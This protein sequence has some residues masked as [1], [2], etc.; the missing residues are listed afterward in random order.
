MTKRTNNLISIAA[1]LMVSPAFATTFG[2]VENFD[3]VNDTGKV[4]HGFEIELEDM[5]ASEVISVFGKDRWLGMERY[6]VPT[7]TE[8]ANVQGVTGA[9]RTGGWNAVV[10]YRD[11]AKSTPSGT[12]PVNPADSCWPLGTP[13]YGP[14]YPCDHF[15]VASSVAAKNVNY[16]WLVEHTP[17][18]ANNL[19][20]VISGVPAPQWTV[21]PQPP[22]AVPNPIPNAPPI[23]QPQPP[24]VNVVIAV[25]PVPNGWEFGEAKWVKVTAT[26]LLQ[27]IDEG[28]LMAEGALMQNMQTQV[29]WQRLQTD[30]G[31]PLA[32][33]IDLTGVALDPGATGIAYRFEFYTYTGDY[34]P[35]THEAITAPD[36]SG[37]KTPPATVGKFIVAQM[38]GV[39]FDG[40]L[41]A[42]A[43]IPVAPTI[44]ASVVDA[45]LNGQYSATIN[46]TSGNVGDVLNYI[47]TGLPAGLTADP[48]TGVISGSV[49][50]AS[51][52]GKVF[53]LDIKVNDTTNGLS[54]GAQTTMTV[55]DGVINFAPVDQVGT[56]GSVFSYGLA[57]TGGTGIFT[58]SQAINVM[59]PNNVMSGGALPAGLLLDGTTGVIGGIPTLA[60]AYPTTFLATDSAGYTSSYMPIN[61]TINDP[62]IAPPAPTA[63]AGTNE[64][65]TGVN[66]QPN[67]VRD[68]WIETLG[69]AQNGGHSITIPR[70]GVNYT[71]APGMQFGVFQNHMVVTYKG[72]MDAAN[73]FCNATDVS[74]TPALTMIQPAPIAVNYNTAITPVVLQFAGGVAPYSV[75]VTN[76]PA[77]I[78]FD[79]MTNTISGAS[80]VVGPATIVASVTDF[81]GDMVYANISL[82]VNAPAAIVVG[83]STLP[84]GQATVKYPGGS[85]TATGGYGALS[86]TGTGLPPGLTISTAGVI[87]GT[88]T[89]AGTFNPTFTVVDGAGQSKQVAGSISIAPAPVVAT[90]SCTTPKGAKSASGKTKVTAILS[91]TQIKVGNVIVDYAA[92]TKLSNNNSPKVIHVGD[93]AEYQGYVE[94]NGN[95]FGTIITI[96]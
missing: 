90:P 88:P 95:V 11:A 23:M 56:V 86:W 60:G 44:N 45:I 33:Q 2:P 59:L 70:L 42:A 28:D 80:K 38:A 61:F 65:I 73:F 31:N 37:S 83:T 66:Y 34:D 6:G 87:S 69:G 7:V 54:T 75:A 9:P 39:N 46:A 78:T 93:V 94:A 68:P 13:S 63:C 5:R 20:Y 16:N 85:V 3:V 24:K 32:G 81:N 91:A 53:V 47:V 62:V 50:D 57:A 71:F 21:T 29:E 84:A 8:R 10:T 51:L 40:K 76:M 89:T 35:T 19:D 18:D 77:G 25:P 67:G 49:T 17:G 48:V 4:A 15:G 26:G 74:V 27:N 22:V 82:T 30:T 79:T 41:P 96:N 58:Y 64:T 52:I 43:P 12:L 36:T 72:T 92:C 14:L 55:T 1:A